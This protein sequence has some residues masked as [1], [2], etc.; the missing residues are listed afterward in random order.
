MKKLLAL[1]SIVATLGLSG[2]MSTGNDGPA[3]A[4]MNFETMSC[5]EINGVFKD[6]DNKNST[7]SSA[8][9][10]ASMFGVDTSSADMAQAQGTQVIIEAKRTARPIARAKGCS[11]TF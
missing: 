1:T 3:L 8:S 4:D 5:D 6:I 9:S 2:C 10:V 7:A 11:T